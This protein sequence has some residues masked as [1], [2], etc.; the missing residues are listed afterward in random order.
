MK[1]KEPNPYTI[2]R[3]VKVKAVLQHAKQALMGGSGRSL[4]T[5]NLGATS[6]WVVSASPRRFTT[7]TETR[8]P[9]RTRLGGPR[10]RSWYVRKISPPSGFRTPELQP[11]ASHYTS[12]RVSALYVWQR[13]QTGPFCVTL[14]IAGYEHTVRAKHS[15]LLAEFTHVFLLYFLLC[16]FSWYRSFQSCVCQSLVNLKCYYVCLLSQRKPSLT[17]FLHDRS[18]IPCI[19]NLLPNIQNHYRTRKYSI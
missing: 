3:R 19:L 5:L 18:A 11:V 7:G 13:L 4:A 1:F 15:R 12:R 16:V 14:V 6:G 2:T 10:G 9:L 17:W 8:Y